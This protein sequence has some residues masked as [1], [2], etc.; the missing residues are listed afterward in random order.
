MTYCLAIS[1]NKGLVFAS[2]SRTNAGADQVST[3]GKMHVFGSDGDRQIVLLSA[4]NLATTQAV[5]ARIERDIRDGADSHL[6]SVVNL[7]SAAQ[8]VG[9]ILQT[10]EERHGAAVSAAGIN[11]EATFIIGGQIKGARTRLYL[12]YPQGNYITTSKE[13]PFLQLGEVKY[14]KAILDRVVHSPT[15]LDE[16]SLCALVSMDSTIRSNAT[17]GPPIELLSYENDSLC[18]NHYL[19]LE[20]SDDY[21]LEIKRAWNDYLLAAFKTLPGIK[22]GDLKN[23]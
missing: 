23:K 9:Q 12:V 11:A 3:Y 17:V 4:G 19:R 20:E 16:A 6:M 5:I 10:Q 13:T 22:W 21:L 14:G 8:Y 18:I 1:V 2:D 15:S 7:E